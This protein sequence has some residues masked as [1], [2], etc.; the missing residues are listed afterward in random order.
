MKNPLSQ[1]I[2]NIDILIQKLGELVRIKNK[3][4]DAPKAD[5]TEPHYWDD[6]SLYGIDDMDNNC[7]THNLP[8]DDMIFIAIGVFIVVII[9]LIVIA[10]VLFYKF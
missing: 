2:I 4:N 10:V 7:P 9:L 5:G 3:K 8:E 6:E 1:S